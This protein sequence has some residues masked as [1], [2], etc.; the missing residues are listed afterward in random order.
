MGIKE[1]LL[2]PRHNFCKKTISLWE[3][4]FSEF[5]PSINL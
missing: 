5:S 4:A 2:R 1:V 3:V